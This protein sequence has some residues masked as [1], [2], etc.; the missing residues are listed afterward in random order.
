MIECVEAHYDIQDVEIG[1][2]YKWCP[3]RAVVECTCGKRETFIAFRTPTCGKCGTDHA[4]IIGEVLDSRPIFWRS[5][6]SY[7]APTRG[8]Y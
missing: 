3:E 5:V 6:N 1:T 4:D 2:V 7:Y 8:T